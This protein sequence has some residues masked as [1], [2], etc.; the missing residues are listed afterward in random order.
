VN[1]SHGDAAMASID[2]RYRLTAVVRSRSGTYSV[3][4]RDLDSYLVPKRDLAVTKESLHASG[5]GVG[6]AKSP[7]AYLFDRVV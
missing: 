4:S 5:R 3:S 1:P 7:F 6:Y 2:P